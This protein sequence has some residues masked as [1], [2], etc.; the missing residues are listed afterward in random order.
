MSDT[1]KIRPALTKEEWGVV[2]AKLTEIRNVADTDAHEWGSAEAG[3]DAARLTDAI[4]RIEDGTPFG[5][6]PEDVERLQRIAAGHKLETP[7][8][9]ASDLADRIAALLPPEE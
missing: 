9:W 8:A 4:D 5:L 3:V 2:A 7:E 1:S 6:T